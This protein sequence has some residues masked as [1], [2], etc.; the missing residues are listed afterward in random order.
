V[1][2]CTGYFNPELWGVRVD[3]QGDVTESHV[4]WTF[5]GAVSDTPSPTIVDGRVYLVS[6]TGVGTVVDLATG[7]RISRFRL[8]GNYS[9]SPVVAGGQLYFCDEAG[10]TK[11][12]DAVDKPRVIASNRLDGAMK[13]SPA[14]LGNA[15]ILRT[16]KA[17][18]RI[19]E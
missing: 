14:V 10:R 4:A 19:E 16:D 8:G 7:I 2:F 12:V 11:I 3:G 9:A 13:A 1:V 18:Y 17:L 15:I 6:N 5:R